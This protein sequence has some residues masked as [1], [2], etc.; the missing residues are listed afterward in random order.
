MAEEEVAPA[1]P[2]ETPVVIRIQRRAVHLRGGEGSEGL[3]IEDVGGDSFQCNAHGGSGR[4][5]AINAAAS[6]AAN[7]QSKRDAVLAIVQMLIQSASVC[8][9]FKSSFSTPYQHLSRGH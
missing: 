6:A 2:L 9:V 3:A 8:F 7:V 5:G 1:K 4:T